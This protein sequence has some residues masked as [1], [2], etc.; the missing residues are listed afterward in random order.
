MACASFSCG[1]VGRCEKQAH[2]HT[3]NLKRRKH[4]DR[5]RC[6]HIDARAGDYAHIL[7]IPQDLIA[8][9]DPQRELAH[10]R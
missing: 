5:G 10:N 7:L 3:L 6:R 2:T 1:P 4:R 9:T 8:G